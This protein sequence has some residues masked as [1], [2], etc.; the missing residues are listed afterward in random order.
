M[1][2]LSKSVLSA[3]TIIKMITASIK[4]AF[5]IK[6]MPF[7]QKELDELADKVF[8]QFKSNENTSE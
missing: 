2:D 3:N 1:S 6:G 8:T 5:E 7:T 4:T